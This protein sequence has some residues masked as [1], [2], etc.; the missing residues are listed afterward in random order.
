MSRPGRRLGIRPSLLVGLECCL[1][2]EVV[3]FS[4]S[5]SEGTTSQFAG[6]R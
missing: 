6:W 1:L 3:V 5:D 4:E 2:E